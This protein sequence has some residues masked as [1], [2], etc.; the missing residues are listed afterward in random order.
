M[1]MSDLNLSCRQAGAFIGAEEHRGANVRRVVNLTPF[2]IRLAIA[3]LLFAFSN[4]ASVGIADS[5]RQSEIASSELTEAEIETA[6]AWSLSIEELSQIRRLKSQHQGLVSAELTPLEWL[7]IFAASDAQRNHYARLFARR[8]L[9]TTAAILEFEA[10]YIKAVRELSSKAT[11]TAQNSERLIL[12]TSFR[13]SDANCAQ[14]L[15]NGLD[16]VN[17]GGSLDVYVQDSRGDFNSRS[18][19]GINQIPHETLRSGK[20]A[21]RQAEGRMLEV[22][23]G[24]YRAGRTNQQRQVK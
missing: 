13:C 23:P 20:I 14:L 21:I 12:V 4:P 11:H 22:R 24:I 1:S 16:H 5:I 18:W 9:E 10:A 2:A 7:G 6:E 19:A 3:V 8:Q 15:Q 17:R